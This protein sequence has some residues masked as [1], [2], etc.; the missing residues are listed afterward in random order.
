[1]YPLCGEL[2]QV[3]KYPPTNNL[4][5]SNSFTFEILSFAPTPELNAASTVP[6]VL[7]LTIVLDGPELMVND[8][9]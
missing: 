7:S 8:D 5:S 4:P 6:S 2:F 3:V 9:P 1:M